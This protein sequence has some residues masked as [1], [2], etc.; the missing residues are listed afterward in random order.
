MASVGWVRH[1]LFSGQKESQGQTGDVRGA[2]T[3]LV[4]LFPVKNGAG[5]RAGW[6]A[7]L[8]CRARRPQTDRPAR[9]AEPAVFCRSWLATLFVTVTGERW[10]KS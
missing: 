6:P 2:K 10:T 5:G 9:S 1:L 4:R 3:G 7:A 8:A